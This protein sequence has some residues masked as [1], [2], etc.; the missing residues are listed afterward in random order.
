MPC[1]CP[2]RF[3]RSP[4]ATGAAADLD[5]GGGARCRTGGWT[6][7]GLPYLDRAPPPVFLH[8][9]PSM[10]KKLPCGLTCLYGA[11]GPGWC[12]PIFR[13]GDVV[14]AI[15]PAPFRAHLRDQTGII[16]D[17]GRLEALV[18]FGDGEPARKVRCW[19]LS[20]TGA[21]SAGGDSWTAGR[22]VRDRRPEDRGR[23]PAGNSRRG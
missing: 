19:E 18:L 1:R 15:D 23:R 14:R 9:D 21:G 20:P 3:W 5:L 22:R 7:G 17:L 12:C 4:A 11:G 13:P 8:G 16:L 2:A 6:A 10:G